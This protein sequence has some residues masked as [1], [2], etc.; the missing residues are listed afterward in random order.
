MDCV[1]FFVRAGVKI[2]S[3]S[4][5]CLFINS[6][7]WQTRENFYSISTRFLVHQWTVF[8]FV[9]AG[10]KIQSISG[11]DIYLLGQWQKISIHQWTVRVILMSAEACSPSVDC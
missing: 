10:V 5:L 9:R 3:I 7:Q 2:Q 1:F 11:L 8:F 4:G 6:G